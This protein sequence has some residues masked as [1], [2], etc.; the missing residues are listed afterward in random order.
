MFHA[1]EEY[2]KENKRNKTIYDSLFL[3]ITYRDFAHLL[4][5]LRKAVHTALKTFKTI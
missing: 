4:E 5:D 2:F 3:Q 1:I